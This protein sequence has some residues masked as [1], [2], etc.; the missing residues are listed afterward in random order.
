[1]LTGGVSARA[2]VAQLVPNRPS[3]I[4]GLEAPWYCI[5][6]QPALAGPSGNLVSSAPM[7][8]EPILYQPESENESVR[9]KL[10][11]EEL[12]RL[13]QVSPSKLMLPSIS[14]GCCWLAS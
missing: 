14:P 5:S 3:A 4:C 12:A 6:P 11:A 7:V 13:A 2:P 8:L 10:K 1:M 9:S